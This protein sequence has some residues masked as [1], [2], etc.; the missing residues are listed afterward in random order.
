MHLLKLIILIILTSWQK[1]DQKY[2][3]IENE[4]NKI[5]DTKRRQESVVSFAVKKK[6]VFELALL[7]LVASDE[8]LLNFDN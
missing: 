4:I 3:S 6:R 2:S 1:F 5:F 7:M 8:S